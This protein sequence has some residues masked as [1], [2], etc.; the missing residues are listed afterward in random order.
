MLKLPAALQS[1]LRKD[2]KFTAEYVGTDSV[3]HKWEG[4]VFITLPPPFPKGSCD[5]LVNKALNSKA[6]L[7]VLL[8]PSDTSTKWFH[9]LQRSGRCTFKFFESR[10]RWEGHSNRFKNRVPSLLAIVR[11]PDELLQESTGTDK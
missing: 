6:E 10:I 5:V 11:N 2:Y 3:L 9:R 7:I 8:L 1:Q 4:R